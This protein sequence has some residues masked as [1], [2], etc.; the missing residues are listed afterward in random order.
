MKFKETEKLEL[1]KSTSELKEGVISIA[2]I[3]NK[4]GSGELYFGIRNDGTVVG[5]QVGEATLRE[6][7]RAV[8]DHIEPKIYPKVQLA[9]I[10]GKPCIHVEFEGDDSPYFAYGRVYM[11]IADEDRQVSAKEIERLITRKNNYRS[12]WETE[13]SELSVQD[14]GVKIIRQFVRRA[15]EAGRLIYRYDNARNVLHKLELTKG[16]KLLNSARVLFC[17]S[18]S[19]EVQAAV[20][21]GNDKNTF[22][23]IKSFKGNLFDL[24]KKSE[25]Y[26]K[27]HINWRADLSGSQRKDIPE[28]PVRAISE[29]IINSLCH[30]DFSNEKGNEIAIFK[31]RIEIYN[32]GRFPADYSPADFIEGRERSVL[33]NPRIANTLFLTSDIERWGSGLKRIYDACH[34]A[35]VMVEFQPIKSGF[36]VIFHRTEAIL[37]DT[38]KDTVKD[39]HR[40][41]VE[42]L[43]GKE[44]KILKLLNDKPDT[45]AQ[46]LSSR[47]KINLRN[48]KKYLLKLKGKGI[49]RRIG[50]DKGGHWEI[51]RK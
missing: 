36:L 21:A 23:D 22:L 18:S 32:P 8:S 29:A 50:P 24:I 3:L 31:N 13:V 51:V 42:G 6:V 48:T 2:S 26:I 15:N 17:E 44:I 46:S 9:S 11:R 47:L 41:T 35:G 38:Q 20:F 37:R 14:A 25:S 16:S 4:H 40:D 19:L 39:T 28:I 5:Q 43:S 7:S 34:E 49:L 10:D 12:Q 27:E 33:R 30:R 1:K 45:T